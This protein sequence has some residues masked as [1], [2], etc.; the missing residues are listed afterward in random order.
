[1][2]AQVLNSGGKLLKCSN[3]CY[4]ASNTS[5]GGCAHIRSTCKEQ[6]GF[7]EIGDIV[8]EGA[9]GTL[10][11]LDR[12]AVE[13]VAAWV[14]REETVSQQRGNEKQLAVVG[15][16]GSSERPSAHVLDFVATLRATSQSLQHRQTKHSSPSDGLHRSSN[17]TFRPCGRTTSCTSLKGDSATSAMENGSLTISDCS[18]QEQCGKDGPRATKRKA[19]WS[20]PLCG[21]MRDGLR[22]PISIDLD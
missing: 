21:R 5:K 8:A 6:Q 12:K 11:T 13:Q 14:N 3:Y 16:P 10:S 9:L 4:W 2:N 1:M 17:T 18:I 7:T 15:S 22:C 20:S 19:C